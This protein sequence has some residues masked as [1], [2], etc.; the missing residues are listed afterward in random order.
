G[1]AT[2]GNQ[3]SVAYSFSPPPRCRISHAHLANVYTPSHLVSSKRSSRIINGPACPQADDGVSASCP[4]S[5]SGLAGPKTALYL[6]RGAAPSASNRETRSP[7]STI[8]LAQRRQ[9]D[10]LGA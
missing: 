4:R 10:M 1:G 2:F 8:A 6:L 9:A 3:K 5:A 7:R